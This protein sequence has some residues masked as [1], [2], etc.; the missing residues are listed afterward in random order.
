MSVQ[1]VTHSITPRLFIICGECVS[2]PGQLN[3]YSDSLR[4][5][6]SGDRI[7]VGYRCFAS[8]QTGPE[9]TQPPVIGCRLCFSGMELKGRGFDHPSHLTSR[10]KKE[11]SCKYLLPMCAFM[12]CYRATCTFTDG[13]WIHVV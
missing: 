6:R 12:G 9:A 11:Y 7:L 5:G 8:V 4:A 3:R 10:L 1:G 13:E 2:G